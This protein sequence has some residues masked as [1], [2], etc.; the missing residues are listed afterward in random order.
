MEKAQRKTKW[1][2]NYHLPQMA[3]QFITLYCTQICT[4][5]AHHGGRDRDDCARIIPTI[6]KLYCCVMCDIMISLCGIRWKVEEISSSP[7]TMCD[8]LWFVYISL[9][10]FACHCL[11]ESM[12]QKSWKYERIVPWDITIWEKYD[13]IFPYIMQILKYECQIH[14]CTF[15]LLYVS[16]NSIFDAENNHMNTHTLLEHK[17]MS[18]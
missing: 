6:M 17:D 7:W 16:T 8:G 15:C 11:S 2:R 5:Y 10:Y 13:K 4:F 18:N 14:L 9:T 1:D 3:M 12:C